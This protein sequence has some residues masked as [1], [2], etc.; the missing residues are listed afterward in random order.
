MSEDKKEKTTK[1]WRNLFLLSIK[2]RTGM[3]CGRS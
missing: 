1:D 2:D 3:G